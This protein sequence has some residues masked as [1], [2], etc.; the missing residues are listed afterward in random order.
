M[1]LIK[2]HLHMFIMR[3]NQVDPHVS[4]KDGPTA[5][6]DT[7]ICDFKFTVCLIQVLSPS[8]ILDP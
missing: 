6:L 7:D 5:Y 8:I 2:V 1:F 3:S 4:Y